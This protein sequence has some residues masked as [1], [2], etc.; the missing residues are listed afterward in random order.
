MRAV[1]SS[2]RKTK[3][4]ADE[5]VGPMTKKQ[6]T[7]EAVPAAARK[8]MDAAAVTEAARTTKKPKATRRAS[9]KGTTNQVHVYLL[10]NTAA[11]HAFSYAPYKID[12]CRDMHPTCRGV[13]RCQRWARSWALSLLSLKDMSPLP[14]VR[15]AGISPP[16]CADMPPPPP[17]SLITLPCPQH[18]CMRQHCRPVCWNPTPLSM[19]TTLPS[20]ALPLP[21]PLFS[22]QNTRHPG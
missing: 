14:H 6:T 12:A 17:L 10:R 5:H 7:P 22:R 21:S 1:I 4:V 3:R 19:A 11:F 18:A 9:T 15:P 16:P 2:S 20:P 13:S 8:P